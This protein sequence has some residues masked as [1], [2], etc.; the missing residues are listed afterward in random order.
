MPIQSALKFR[1]SRRRWLAGL[2]LCLP[3]FA[4]S[5]C[6]NE[7]GL[8][9]FGFETNLDDDAALSVKVR[10][11]L[12]ESAETAGV[13]ILV[14]TRNDDFVRLSGFVRTQRV[15]EAAEQVALAVD[16]VSGVVNTLTVQN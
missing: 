7:A 4:F 10:A 12:A 11:A 9:E 3:L 16:G 14:T 2:T 1:Q 6:A 13:R 15:Y 8:G 5:G